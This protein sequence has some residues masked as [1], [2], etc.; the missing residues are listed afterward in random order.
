MPWSLTPLGLYP[1]CFLPGYLHLHFYP[2]KSNSPFK[3]RINCYFLYNQTLFSA[4]TGLYKYISYRIYHIILPRLDYSFQASGVSS[5]HH[6]ANRQNQ[7]QFCLNTSLKNLRDK[8]I[9]KVAKSLHKTSG[10]LASFIETLKRKEER[11]FQLLDM[12]EYEDK[13]LFIL[14]TQHWAWD[15][16]CTRCSINVGWMNFWR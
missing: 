4:S 3:V 10:N 7:G 14:H 1:A 9:E 8:G 12:L 6:M 2:E 15:F 11:I 5:Y 13:V 16:S